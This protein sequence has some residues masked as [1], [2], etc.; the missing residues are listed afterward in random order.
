MSIKR[1]EEFLGYVDGTTEPAALIAKGPMYDK[2]LSVASD[3]GYAVTEA[4]ET[5]IEHLSSGESV[6]LKVTGEIPSDLYDLLRQYSHR[7][8]AIQVLPK[9]AGTA[10]LLQLDAEKTKLLLIVPAEYEAKNTTRYP[11]LLSLV[12]LVERV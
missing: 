9:V 10:P 1:V 7:R 4:Y 2:A 6:A 5:A 8:G 12:G 3:N 11:E